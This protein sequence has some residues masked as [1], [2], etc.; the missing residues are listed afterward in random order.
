MAGTAV[1]VSPAGRRPRASRWLVRLL[2][3]GAMLGSRRPVAR[4]AAKA[5]T[6]SDNFN[7]INGALGSSW[8]KISDGALT[9]SSQAVA[10]VATSG[11]TGDL[12]TAS[13]FSGNQFSQI[14]TTSTAMTGGQWIGVAVRA[15]STGQQ[16][17]VG[18]YFWN[19][20]TPQLLL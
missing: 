1:A 3:V 9:I 18:V 11:T 7:R 15:N 2:A 20:G 14:T 13:A 5:A 17:Y 4:G 19:H 6:A 12:W 8:T 16:A 10:G